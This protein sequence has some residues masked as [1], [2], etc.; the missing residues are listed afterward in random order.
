MCFHAV[1]LIAEPALRGELSRHAKAGH[2]GELQGGL[3]SLLSLVGGVAPVIGALI[4]SGNVGS[5][6]HFLWL[7]APFLV[8]LL[9]YV[10]AIGCIQRGRTSAA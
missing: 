5:G 2:Q 4:F 10:L 7:G 1:G 8:S 9:M 6:E 3:T